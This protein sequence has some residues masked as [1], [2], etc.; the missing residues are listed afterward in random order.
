[1]APVVPDPRRIKAFESE[2]AFET[3]PAAHH[4]TEPAM[5]TPAGRAR[6]IAALVAMLARGETIVPNP[7]AR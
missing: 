6:E 3:W 1:M 4:D 2:A 7:K 5:K